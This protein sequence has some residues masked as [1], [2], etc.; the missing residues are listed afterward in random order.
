MV[1][2]KMV[3][4]LWQ[5]VLGDIYHLFYTIKL[6]TKE[7]VIAI[8]DEVDTNNAFSYNWF[9]ARW[10]R[11]LTDAELRGYKLYINSANTNIKKLGLNNPLQVDIANYPR[12]I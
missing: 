5:G 8:E 9:P 1:F 12:G 3:M 7:A 6:T 2:G 10:C 11:I 4:A